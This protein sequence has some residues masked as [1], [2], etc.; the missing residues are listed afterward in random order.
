MNKTPKRLKKRL[1]DF[2]F[3]ARY[4]IRR[5]M[6][7]ERLTATKLLRRD[8]N[9]A[10]VWLFDCACGGSIEAV[11]SKV[12]RGE[13][14]SCGCLH[15]E[16]KA[17]LKSFYITTICECGREYKI[18]KY[19]ETRGCPLCAGRLRKREWARR[20]RERTRG[21]NTMPKSNQLY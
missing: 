21:D 3:N 15:E 2:S 12:Y 11:G 5:G 18:N 10:W 7:F 1:S 20:N 6:E 8:K 9:G 14:Q 16:N 4:R 19:K 17:R 13:I